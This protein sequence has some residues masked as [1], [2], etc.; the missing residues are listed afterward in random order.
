MKTEA[1]AFDLPEALCAQTPPEARG[2]QRDQ[3]KLLVSSRQKGDHHHDYFHSLGQYLRPGDLLVVNNS[4]TIAASLPARIGDRPVRLHLSTDL[5]DG[6]WIVEV[7]TAAG[8]PDATNLPTGTTIDVVGWPVQA[9]VIQRYRDFARLWLVEMTGAPLEA[10]KH[11]GSPIRYPYVLGDW[12]LRF[13][14]TLFA[15]VEGAAEMPSAGRPFTPRVLR[16]LRAGGVE[17][18]EITL[19]TGVSSHDLVHGEVEEHGTYPEWYHIPEKTARAVEA[20]KTAGRRVIA[21]GTTV[22]RALESAADGRGGVVPSS[23]FTELFIHPGYDLKVVD[24]LITGLHAPVT[25]HLAL[26]CAFMER[27]VIMEAYDEAIAKGYLWH[28]FGDVHLIV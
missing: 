2:L 6:R 24:G 17:I 21:V 28:E 16:F 25:S 27:D 12:P 18:A 22:V 20:A 5:Y 14:Q 1:L 19:H 10:A 3:V 11:V 26:L 9:T 7:R 23:G 4:K 13:Y 15:K 8:A